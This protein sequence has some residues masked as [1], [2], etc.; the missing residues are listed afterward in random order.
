MLL[1]LE[2][3]D[4][5]NAEVIGNLPALTNELNENQ[6]TKEKLIG[7]KTKISQAIGFFKKDMDY[8][9]GKL[10]SRLEVK[11][12]KGIITYIIKWNIQKRR[13]KKSGILPK[14]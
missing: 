11:K 5:S 6:F 12:G 9:T 4:N 8:V 2:K 1:A 3:R 10:V 7:E 14:S 13:V